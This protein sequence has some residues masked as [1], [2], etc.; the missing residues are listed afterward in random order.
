MPFDV[1]PLPPLTYPQCID[2]LGETIAE[3][4]ELHVLCHTYGCNREARVNL[5]ALARRLGPKH[6][7]MAQDIKPYFHCSRCRA[8]GEPDR[9]ISFRLQSASR[10]VCRI[11][12]K[13]KKFEPN[14][15]AKA[16]GQ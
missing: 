6:S 10:D 14:P 3:G 4:H 9:N 12:D 15:Y 5:I 16:K 7:C 8:A 2:T 11:T 13:G 1:F